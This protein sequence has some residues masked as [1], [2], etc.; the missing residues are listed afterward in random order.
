MVK[1][2]K[3]ARDRRKRKNRIRMGIFFASLFS[4]FVGTLLSLHQSNNANSLGQN[5][6]KE[7]YRSVASSS[8]D[9][10]NS[11]SKNKI[12]SL[13]DDTQIEHS[14]DDGFSG[15]DDEAEEIKSEPE[16]DLSDLPNEAQNALNDLFDVADKAIRIRNQFS[17]TVVQGDTLKDILELSGIDIDD[18]TS[19][20]LI[21]NYPEL[22]NLE[23]GQQFYWILNRDNQLDYMNWLVSEKE[24]RIYERTAEGKYERQIIEK[25]SFWKKD[26]LRGEVETSFNQSL[27][28]LGLNSRQIAQLTSALQWQISMRK[29]KKGDKFA[30]LVS[31]EYLGNELTGQGNVEAIHIMT[32]GKSYYAIQAEN[33]RYYNRH[34]ETLGK[35]FARYP[36]Q[37]QPRISSPFNPRRI[38][39]ITH[40]IRP[41]NGVDFSVPIGTPVIAPA[42]GQVIKIAYQARG[43]GRYIV[44]RHSREYET[45]YMHLSKS[46]VKI[47]QSVKRGDRIA[48]SGNTGGST[49]AHLHYE[50]HINGRP[51]NPITVKLPGGNIGMGTKERKKFLTLANSLEEKLK[52]TQ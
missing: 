2:I 43:A 35:G 26:V 41:H 15:P 25:K 38:H 23:V 28:K 3:F 16:E 12:S 14:Y 33:G 4:I 29:L 7:T 11:E 27:K 24:E 44:V 31:R 21:E 6:Q 36:L 39:P 17:H 8:A 42:D 50:F 52:L 20:R 10:E 40:Q 30:L 22:K 48:L 9:Q 18:D 37:R 51:V 45:V 19:K 32:G 46:L 47:G 13:A 49:G 34:G 1:P 5:T